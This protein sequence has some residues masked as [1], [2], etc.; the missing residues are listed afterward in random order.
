MR[1]GNRWRVTAMNPDSSRLIARRLDDNTLGAF[2]GDY[3][4]EHITHGYA[5]TIHCAQGVTADTTHAIAGRNRYP[6]AALCRHDTRRDTN[7]AYLYESRTEQER[8][9]AT[10]LTMQHLMARG[11]SRDAA[12]LARVI[13]THHD[14][15][16]T[17]HRLPLTPRQRP[18][19]DIVAALVNRTSALSPDA[20][21]TTRNAK[22]RWQRR[23]LAPS[24]SPRADHRPR[25]EHRRRPR[26]EAWPAEHQWLAD[27]IFRAKAQPAEPTL[28]SSVTPVVWWAPS[29][30]FVSGRGSSEPLFIE[31][32]LRIARLID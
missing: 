27:A 20:A 24:T 1:N 29:A 8:R 26:T 18:C 32:K 22:A 14:Q 7:T 5:V 17:A 23:R 12:H 3:L 10:N 16:A 19:Q 28:L 21:A 13:A 2:S 30:V 15:P 6:P 4:R 25:R 9:N 31:A 11:T